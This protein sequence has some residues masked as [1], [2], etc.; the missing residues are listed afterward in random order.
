MSFI[1]VLEI[2]QA[3]VPVDEASEVLQQVQSAIQT[4]QRPSSIVDTNEHEQVHGHLPGEVAILPVP[5]DSS[6]GELPY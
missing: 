6:P 5:A 2:A 3:E 1:A 4:I